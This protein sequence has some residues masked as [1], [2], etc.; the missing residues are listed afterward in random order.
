[1]QEKAGLLFEGFAGTMAPY[2]ALYFF[3]LP[4]DHSVL[5]M[6]QGNKARNSSISVLFEFR[7]E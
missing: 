7:K 5:P 6:D 1:M 2:I 3:V 4:M